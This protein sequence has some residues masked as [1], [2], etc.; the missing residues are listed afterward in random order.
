[1]PLKSSKARLAYDRLR[2]KQPERIE[3]NKIR[4]RKWRQTP[5]GKYSV[6]KTSAK[7][8]GIAWEFTFETWWN[9]WEKVFHLRGPGPEQLCMARI[10]D[11]GPYS[12]TNIKLITNR[13]ND[14]E[15]ESLRKETT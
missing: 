12:P 2:N 6:Q 10:G 3:A 1:M 13:E 8:R 11:I 15:R 5:K 14:R 4:R 9:V 7:Q